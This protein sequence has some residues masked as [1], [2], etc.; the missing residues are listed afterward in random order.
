MAEKFIVIY[1]TDDCRAEIINAKMVECAFIVLPEKTA[2]QVNWRSGVS[3]RKYVQRF[4]KSTC[5]AKRFCE[6]V[7]Q[8]SGEKVDYTLCVKPYCSPHK[9]GK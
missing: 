4:E 2:V 1:D 9:E 3:L 6:I 8:L 5:A 7:Q